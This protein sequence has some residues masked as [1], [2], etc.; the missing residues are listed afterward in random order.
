LE[1]EPLKAG[2]FKIG[3]KIENKFRATLPE[4]NAI[5]QYGW[6]APFASIFRSICGGTSFDEMHEKHQQT[7]IREASILYN[8]AFLLQRP[9][10]E[11]PH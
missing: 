1:T 10:S 8:G 7:I 5:P 4:K 6:I 2:K 11:F 9:N 3:I